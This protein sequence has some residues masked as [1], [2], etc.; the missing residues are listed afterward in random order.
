MPQSRWVERLVVLGS[1]VLVVGYLVYLSFS[2]PERGLFE[3][4]ANDF[5]TFYATGVI[6]RQGHL[7]AI[8]HLETQA[9]VQRPIFD[10][11]AGPATGTTF[12]PIPFPYLPPFALIFV[13]LSLLQPVPALVLWLIIN[14]LI[15][16]ASLYWAASGLK[17]D[18]SRAWIRILAISVSL[19][20]FLN[21][22]F[23][24]VNVLLLLGVVGSLL[25]WRRG[26]ERAAGLWLGLLLLKPQSVTLLVLGLAISG[27]W[28]VVGWAAVSG[29]ALGLTSMLLGG[30][31][32]I[33]NLVRLLWLY[34]QGLATTYPQSMMN[35][36][37]AGLTLTPWV[38]QGAA[39]AVTMLG[40]F[41]TIISV[42][43]VWRRVRNDAQPNLP[44]I[45]A[46]SLAGSSAI[47]WH[48]HIHMAL[49]L[50]ALIWLPRKVDF[51]MQAT[52][53]FWSI[54]IALA[55]LVT[56]TA[57]DP[58]R[59]HQVAGILSLLGNMLVL[60]AALTAFPHP[61]IWS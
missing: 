50:I 11:H 28:R 48:S 61:R 14:F 22:A 49:P 35:W 5:R 21:F 27:K 54:G 32:G 44:L 17:L 47:S 45:Y 34:P 51:V 31:G 37:S 33:I 2:L 25:G 7:D 8:Y 13:P 30:L 6:A 23:A 9:E 15:L 26:E 43:V 53:V 20:V 39:N 29:I 3:Y 18:L 52:R 42:V 57:T 36:R 58:G 41:L 55:F 24:Q 1:L 10:K 56:L 19:P 12:A 38:G 4:W 40:I 60:Y 59:A 46:A 16:V